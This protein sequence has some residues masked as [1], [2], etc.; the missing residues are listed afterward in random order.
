MRTMI[1]L[2]LCLTLISCENNAQDV[3]DLSTKKDSISYAIGLN[4]GDSFKQQDMDIDLD[5]LLGGINHALAE[6]EDARLLSKE[7]IQA[8]MMSFQQEMMEKQQAKQEAAGK[9]NKEA[10]EKFL[11]ENKTKE[12]VKVTESGLQY[13]IIEEG[14]GPIPTDKDKV[15]VHYTGTLLDGTKF[16]SSFD[17]G[18]PATFPVTGVIKGWTEA[19]QMM[20]VGSKWKLWIPGE[21]AYGPQGAGGQIGPNQTLV[22]EVEL[23][24]IDGQ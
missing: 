8:V 15:T 23:L 6:E 19:L 1:A 18:E 3:S 7:Q 11:A 2:A 13:K 20:P 9:E 10:G 24:S 14:D 12:G 22:F 4:I 21:L 16:D 5:V 17:R